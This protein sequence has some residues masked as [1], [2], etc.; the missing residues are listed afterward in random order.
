MVNYGQ[1]AN[2]HLTQKYGFT[3]KDNPNN[4]IHLDAKFYNERN[5]FMEE[6]KFKQELI[7]KLDLTPHVF[8]LDLSSDKFD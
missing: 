1:W 6:G 4:L 5:W 7:K 3:L 2:L 8:Y